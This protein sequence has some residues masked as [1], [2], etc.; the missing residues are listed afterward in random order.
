MWKPADRA[1]RRLSLSCGA[2]FFCLALAGTA[3]AKPLEQGIYLKS[4]SVLL[5]ENKLRLISLDFK[6]INTLS[7]KAFSQIYSLNQGE[8]FLGQTEDGIYLLALVQESGQLEITQMVAGRELQAQS[9]PQGNQEMLLVLDPLEGKLTLINAEGATRLAYKGKISE[10]R[11]IDPTKALLTTE[12][13]FALLSR[14][15]DSSHPELGSLSLPFAAADAKLALMP[16]QAILWS[17]KAASYLDLKDN[18]IH[19]LP[20][21][22]ADGIRI[23]EGGAILASSGKMLF[24]RQP[25]SKGEAEREFTVPAML[26]DKPLDEQHIFSP[27]PQQALVFL[28]E[29]DQEALQAIALSAEGKVEAVDLPPGKLKKIITH[30]HGSPLIFLESSSLEPK[31]D[32][33]GL[34]VFDLVTGKPQEITLSSYKILSYRNKTFLTIADEARAGLVGP[35]EKVGDTVL[36]TTRSE[37]EHKLGVRQSIDLNYPYS[38]AIL[39]GLSLQEPDMAWN[40]TKARGENISKDRLPVHS[41]PLLTVG[42]PIILTSEGDRVLAIDPDSGKTLWQSPKI[43]MDESIPPLFSWPN[44]LGLEVSKGTS[45]SLIALD[46]QNGKLR[47]DISMSSVFIAEKWRHLLGLIIVC[48][49]LAYYIYAARKRELYVRQIAGLKALDEAVGRATEMGKPVLYVVGL[50]DV[51]DIQ[52][53]ASLSIL[54]HVAKKTAEYD[55]PI[56]ATTSR[57]VTFSA[58]QEIVRDAFSVAGHPDAF[59]IDSVRYITDDQFGYTAGV[60]GIMVREKPAAN[61]YIGKFYAESLI[62]AETGFATGAIQIAGTAEASQIP[63]FVAA[64]DYTLIGE[65]LFA[66]SAYLSRDPL[67]VGSLRGQ[68]VGKMLVM[69]ILVVCS[70]LLSFGI[71]LNSIEKLLGGSSS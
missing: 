15:K 38:P 23:L 57:A 5:D 58:A 40:Y 30:P 42:G 32:E 43:S 33:N 17:H 53:L 60:D 68:D 11:I 28:Q 6:S 69:V 12:N 46:L 20:W 67:Q 51:D 54:S 55:T 19:S 9:W 2:A 63:F 48:A 50:A 47:G 22:A 70:V 52:T 49:A 4:G 56:V 59:S 1:F 31:I 10:L 27:W 13:G 71:D 3:S 7:P 21:A 29:N 45:H 61:F 16:E 64:C 34:P 37:P 65:E 41:Y 66:A 62:L 8:S 35:I 39:H 44:A 18:K 26:K 36:Y 24:L 25:L 14:E